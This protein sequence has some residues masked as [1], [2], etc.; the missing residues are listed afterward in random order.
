MSLQDTLKGRPIPVQAWN[1]YQ[2]FMGTQHDQSTVPALGVVGVR[3]RE[4]SSVVQEYSSLQALVPRL[5]KTYDQ[6]IVHGVIACG[7]CSSSRIPESDKKTA[8]SD[9][10]VCLVMGASIGAP[11]NSI[12]ALEEQ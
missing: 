2:Y 8:S 6:D 1:Q 10:A 11:S 7:G 4:C 3:V 12:I 9:G 5:S